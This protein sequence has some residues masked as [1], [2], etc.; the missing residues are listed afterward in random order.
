MITTLMIELSYSL[1]LAIINTSC[2]C[3][4]RCKVFH[5]LRVLHLHIKYTECIIKLISHTYSREATICALKETALK[6]EGAF[7]F[8]QVFVDN[9]ILKYIFKYIKI[10]VMAQIIPELLY[11]YVHISRKTH[12]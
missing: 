1:F 10:L 3:V 6:N 11:S 7:N 4:F 12:F 5:S 9:F 2:I 8:P